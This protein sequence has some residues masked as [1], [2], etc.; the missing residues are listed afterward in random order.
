[1]RSFGPEDKGH[2]MSIQCHALTQQKR[3]CRKNAEDGELFCFTHAKW[4]H[5]TTPDLPPEEFP[6]PFS[7]EPPKLSK[8]SRS[9]VRRRIL[10]RNVYLD[11]FFT[12]LLCHQRRGL[13][14]CPELKDA[15]FHHVFVH[16][17]PHSEELTCAT[18]SAGCCFCTDKSAKRQT[19]GYCPKCKELIYHQ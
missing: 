5:K 19:Q 15:I 18:Q 11:R 7:C 16:G 12:F 8:L 2:I 17:C 6:S 3:R 14:L 4:M 1:M 9:K 13:E 10:A